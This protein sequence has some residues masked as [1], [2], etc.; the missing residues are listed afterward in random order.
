MLTFGQSHKWSKATDGLSPAEKARIK[1][2]CLKRQYEAGQIVYAFG[3]PGRSVVI[4][5]SGR[6]R[7]YQSD[8]NGQ[9]VTVCLLSVGYCTGLTSA[10]SQSPRPLSVEAVD[11]TS[12]LEIDRPT[13]LSLMADIPS[14]SIGVTTLLASIAQEAMEN[15][16]WFVA[17]SAAQ[18]LGHTLL[19]LTRND[20]TLGGTSAPVIC[21]VGHEQLASMVGVSRTWISLT[22]AQMEEERLICR[23][24]NRIEILDARGLEAYS[25]PFKSRSD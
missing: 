4:V 18:R 21:G 16:S 19:S 9:E 11:D 10:L 1:S 2:S 23:S 5:E 17:R 25:G 12:V 20:E 6:L 15:T 3:Q 8:K 22:L 14:F 13:L 7:G 24:R